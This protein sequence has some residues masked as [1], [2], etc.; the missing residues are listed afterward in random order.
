MNRD[1][2]LGFSAYPFSIMG[3]ADRTHSLASDG[4]HSPAH[5]FESTTGRSARGVLLYLQ[6]SDG[7]LFP[8]P[9]DL[10]R[11]LIVVFWG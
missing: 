1:V 2:A 3:V 8:E 6:V 9:K 4:G 5:D 11:W 7:F 10:I